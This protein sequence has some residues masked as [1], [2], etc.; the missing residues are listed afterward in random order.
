MFTNIRAKV[1]AI[2]AQ[3][4]EICLPKNLMDTTSQPMHRQEASWTGLVATL[5]IP[6]VN[7]CSIAP[8]PFP[9]R[10]ATGK[11][12]RDSRPQQRKQLILEPQISTQP[13]IIARA[14]MLMAF[15]HLG[16]AP[17]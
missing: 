13:N 7:D 10:F 3:I 9:R 17:G 12:F 5:L 8:H 16:P 4:Q 6:R 15:G 1:R 11:R 2:V 14:G